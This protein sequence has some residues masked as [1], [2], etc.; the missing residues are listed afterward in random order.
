MLGKH[1]AN[2][3]EKEEEKEKEE[4]EEKRG[5]SLYRRQHL[6]N[7]SEGCYQRVREYAHNTW[8]SGLSLLEIIL[9]GQEN[10]GK[11]SVRCYPRMR[12][13]CG[14]VEVECG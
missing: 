13:N 14:G 11:Q 10:V 9:S 2:E 7:R 3:E 5:L 12:Y 4:D 6:N 1:T 8:P